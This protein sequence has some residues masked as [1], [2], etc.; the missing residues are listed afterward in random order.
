[1][2]TKN[3][4]TALFTSM[5]TALAPGSK[6]FNH[7]IP[8]FI[9]MSKSSK[10]LMKG[11]VQDASKSDQYDNLV[12]GIMKLQMLIES[13][14]ICLVQYKFWFTCKNWIRGFELKFAKECS[15][16][17]KWIY[18]SKAHAR[19]MYDYFVEH[20]KD[21]EGLSDSYSDYLD[22]YLSEEF[23]QKAD[24]HVI[25]CSPEIEHYLETMSPKEYTAK[26]GPYYR[27]VQNQLKVDQGF[28]V[29]EEVE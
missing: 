14:D 21:Y 2:D 15:F 8:K 22:A 10:D 7:S 20:L 19:E 28:K 5:K 12:D 17:P 29:E 13:D 25:H 3:T 18:T 4:E 23:L 9:E 11:L 24:V 1:M 16:M 27:K 6:K 26:W